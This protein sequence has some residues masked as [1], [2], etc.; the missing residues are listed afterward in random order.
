MY[1]SKSKSVLNLNDEN[2]SVAIRL[3][4]KSTH[5]HHPFAEYH[6][7]VLLLLLLLADESIIAQSLCFDLILSHWYVINRSN[8]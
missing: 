3:P 8:K 2:N 6:Q 7:F 5:L 4:C 1:E